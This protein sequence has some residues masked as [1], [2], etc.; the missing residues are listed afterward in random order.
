MAFDPKSAVVDEANSKFDAK[1][2][3]FDPESAFIEDEITKRQVSRFDYISNQAKLGLTDTA[4]L[5]EAILD[6]FLI[7]PLKTLGSKFGI[8][9]AATGGIGE[10][11][12]KNVQRLQKAGAQITGATPGQKA[13]DVVTGIVGSGIRAASDPVGYV[14]APLKAVPMLA[15]ATGL[16][17]IGSTAEVGGI[18][19]EAAE[20]GLFGTETGTGRAVGSITAA[21]KG[22]PVATAIQ[23]AAGGATNVVG[24]VRNKYKSF[25]EDPAAANEAYATGAAKRLLNIIAKEQ[26]G[27]KLDEVVTEFNRISNVINKEELPLMVAMADN[28]AVRQQVE[29]LAK[30]NPDF[31]AR[32]N[33]ELEKLAQNIDAR[34]D[35]LFGT[36]YTPI[37]G[38]ETV[39]TKSAIKRRQQVDDQIASLTQRLDT[40]ADEA[41]IGKAISNLVEVKQKAARAEIAPVYQSIIEDAKKA[42]AK[43]PEEGVR[44]IYNFVVGNR[45]RDIFGK[46]TQIDKDVIKNFGP[47]DG[48]FFPASFEAVD[49]L[50]RRINELQR[51]RLTAD[52]ARR[53]SQ[54]E[55]LLTAERANIP[56]NFSQRLAD[57]DRLYYEKVGVPFSAQ[58]IKDID[59]KNYAEQVAPVIVKNGS[60][61]S[62]F[63]GAVGRAEA[64]P[65][66]RNAVLAEAYEKSLKDGVIDSG[67]LRSFINKKSDV[68][69]QLP[70]VKKE[71]DNAVIDSGILSLER[72][73]INDA[74]KAAEKRVADNFV[75]SVKDSSGVAVPDYRELS[76]KLFRDTNFFNKIKKDLGDLDTASSKAVK[77]S[78]RAEII[79]IARNNPAGAVAF[80]T[81]P[82]NARVINNFFGAGYSSA[83]KDLAKLSDAVNKAD[84]GQLSA[85]IERSE[86][87]AL[88]KIVPGLDIPFVTS[89]FRDRIASLPQKI[90][91]L[92]TRVNTA[93]LGD[94][95][96]KA[97]ADLLLDPNGIKA[98]QK[99][100]KEIDFNLQNPLSVKKF[101]DRL[102]TLL[103]QYFYV[104]TKE[105]TLQPESGSIAV[106]ETPM[107]GFVEEQQ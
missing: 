104:G 58:G 26:P 85:T 88:A 83:V 44:N 6:T 61:L 3:Q 69:S 72:Q 70:S 92:A 79:D 46:G 4:V 25:K 45:I 78:I 7:D 16:T 57:T 90:V 76:S 2:A 99:T 65:I 64:E 93:Q 49:S 94:A 34:S 13:P 97:I 62:Q 23:E 60:A 19:G 27:E 68:L 59:A 96:D 39:S 15:R 11:F 71:L 5:G 55:E 35:A 40:G 100:V 12:T 95:T 89:T 91:R 47:R 30:T 103:P 48:D 51:G 18:V 86:L 106:E 37:T 22:A 52:E 53:L 98:L 24:Q 77:N 42:G 9:E 73:R 67:K 28:P 10:R 107:G 20:K 38:F 102:K 56:G 32:V 75:V 17:T 80:I 41:I 43:L 84:I 81:S 74:V 66:A 1:T 63:I 14:G 31:R 29:R 87:D 36:R 54:L 21:V 101:T 50:K 8:S 82:K 105:S 33:T